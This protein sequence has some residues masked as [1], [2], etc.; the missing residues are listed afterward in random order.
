MKG[1]QVTPIVTDEKL[2]KDQLLSDDSLR[3]VFIDPLFKIVR[4]ET[5]TPRERFIRIIKTVI[6]QSSGYKWNVVLQNTMKDSQIGCCSRESYRNLQN[7]GK[8][9]NEAR[10]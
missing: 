2:E 9:I 6:G 1:F 7:L 8:A 5:E 10:R 4:P 3:E